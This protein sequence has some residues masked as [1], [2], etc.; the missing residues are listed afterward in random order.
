LLYCGGFDGIPAGS[1]HEVAEELSN[2]IIERLEAK[3]GRDA[4]I[5]VIEQMRRSYTTFIQ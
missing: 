2:M 1:L 3:E 4:A 5:Q